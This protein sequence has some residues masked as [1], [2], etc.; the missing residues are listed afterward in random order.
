[1]KA[2]SISI[3]VLIGFDDD[4]LGENPWFSDLYFFGI[5]F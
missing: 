4:I 2:G 1:M 5:R 3:T